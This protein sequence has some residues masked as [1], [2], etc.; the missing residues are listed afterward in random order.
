[1]QTRTQG[2]LWRTCLRSCGPQAPPQPFIYVAA[3]PAL[4]A[5]A[6]IRLAL[7]RTGERPAASLGKLLKNKDVQGCA[8]KCVATCIRGGE[9]AHDR[10]HLSQHACRACSSEL[11]P[12]CAGA[13]GLGPLSVRKEV[14]AFKPGFRSRTYCLSEC[15]QACASSLGVK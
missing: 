2:T 11:L 1:M 8:R 6:S 13:P 12:C 7:Q 14:I 3:H 5:K 9:G 4:H 10:P 15:T